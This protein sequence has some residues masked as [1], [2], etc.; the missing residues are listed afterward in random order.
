MIMIY[1]YKLM[2]EFKI[3]KHN[4]VFLDQNVYRYSMKINNMYFNFMII[5]V[6]INLRN[7]NIIS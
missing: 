3:Q 2:K 6:K 5:K 7:E 4:Q 1:N